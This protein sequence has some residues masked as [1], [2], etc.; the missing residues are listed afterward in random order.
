MTMEATR[1]NRGISLFLIFSTLA[2]GWQIKLLH[3]LEKSQLT[4]KNVNKPP[5]L[6]TRP[7][8]ILLEFPNHS[9]R[10]NND[11]DTSL[12]SP[13]PLKLDR[14]R[15]QKAADESDHF[16]NRKHVIEHDPKDDDYYYRHDEDGSAELEKFIPGQ[17]TAQYQNDCVPM[18]TWH[19][20]SFPNC[21]TLHE[22][23][24]STE[25]KYLGSGRWRTAF[26][27]YAYE[28]QAILKLFNIDEW[29]FSRRAFEVHRV[30]A[31]ISERLTHSLYVANIYGYCGL[32]TIYERASGT[33]EKV[34]KKD[35]PIDTKIR[36]SYQMA[37]AILDL[38]SIDYQGG[39]NATVANKDLKAENVL[40]SAD[41][42]NLL[43]SD[44]NDSNLRHWNKTHGKKP[45]PFH[46]RG[47]PIHWGNGYKPVEQATR[48]EKTEG[49]RTYPP[50]SEKVDI[51]ALGGVLYRILTGKNPYQGMD[52]KQV[53]QAMGEGILPEIP[54]QYNRTE[55]E[56]ALGE[57]IGKC[58]KLKPE[59]RPTAQYVVD[60]LRPYVPQN[61]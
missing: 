52:R 18:A 44:F 61:L 39:T 37:H 58:M 59:E 54:P 1:K 5:E 23:Q 4:V 32:T 42:N 10:N 49:K 9:R 46:Y 25:L 17:M 6:L 7:R 24:T 45:C 57:V 14:K 16:G 22:L 33:L 47:F 8:V 56:K 30:D 20:Q 12:P 13:P 35:D 60:Q 41:G 31:I 27:H 53:R 28:E 34:A 29:Y 11:A 51:F 48:Y 15:L 3:F 2:C 43:L 38:H 26:L 36:Y 21:N 50:L 19:K 55:Q 40:I